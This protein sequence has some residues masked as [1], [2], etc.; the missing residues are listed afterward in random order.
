MRRTSN[1]PALERRGSFELTY[2]VR[3]LEEVLLKVSR[4]RSR[5]LRAEPHA[6]D[7]GRRR[8]LK[9]LT[10]RAHSYFCTC[11]LLALA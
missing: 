11:T 3:D 2:N 10:Q 4:A 9:R 5:R 6:G 1:E 8:A 7:S